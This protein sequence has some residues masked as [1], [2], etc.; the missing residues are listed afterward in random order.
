MFRKIIPLFLATILFTSLSSA[1]DYTQDLGSGEFKKK[2]W[3]EDYDGCTTAT[4]SCGSNE[5]LVG[6]E[7]YGTTGEY[8]G[9]QCRPQWEYDLKGNNSCTTTSLDDEWLGLSKE[10]TWSSGT[11]GG[12][13]SHQQC[14]ANSGGGDE[15]SAGVTAY[16]VNPSL[17][18]SLSSP[19]DGYSSNSSNI[20]LEA[21]FNDPTDESGEIYFMN[22]GDVIG[23]C[24]SS[25]GENCSINWTGLSSGTYSWYTKS[26]DGTSN[27]SL[28][29][30]QSFEIDNGN[31]PELSQFSP[32]D[33]N[34]DVEGSVELSVKVE[35]SDSEKMNLTFYNGENDEQLGRMENKDNGTYK[36]NWNGLSEDQTYKWYVTVNDGA[37]TVNSSIHTFTT[38]K[39]DLTWNQNSENEEGFRI[40]QNSSGSFEQ[41]GETV[42]NSV[43]FSDTNQNLD[44]GKYTCYEVRSYNRFGQSDPARGCITP[45]EQ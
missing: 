26:Y 29:A 19:N 21:Q 35:D 2:A 27:S 8:S 44:F 17:A 4:V 45:V 34:L 12:S 5:Y 40:Y 38:I 3:S 14:G 39:T 18:P 7:S 1:A 15:V 28:S 10:R 41:V 24:T 33:T 42:A 6:E 13:I 32:K 36:L 43:S 9:Y 20:T 37:N 23:H 11:Q 31:P 16:C 25:N 22:N 30:T